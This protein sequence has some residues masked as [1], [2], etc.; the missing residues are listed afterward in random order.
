[1]GIITF[2]GVDSSS[3][4]M[5]VETPPNYEIPEKVYSITQ[6]P[7][8]NGDIIIDTKAYKNVDRKYDIAIGARGAKF[9]SL[10]SKI[11]EWLQSGNGYVRLEDSYDPDVFMLALY[12]DGLEILNILQQAGRASIA[13]HRKPQR[14]LKS[15]EKPIV[16][17][18]GGTLKN[19]TQ[20]Q[21]L[22]RIKIYG[23]NS[24]SVKIGKYEI[25][26]EK[27]IDHVIVDS[28]IGDAF[29]DDSSSNLL[30]ELVNGFPKLESVNEISFSGGITKV[31]IIP[32]WW[33]I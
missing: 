20:Y 28:E 2:N 16:F 10:A 11:A 26:I 3:F 27:I 22:P 18:S 17:T 5:V 9:A 33:R 4:D 15:G 6:V 32:R 29:K 8:R 30:V 14:F 21:S 31:E 23:S 25:K 7:G 12:K 1:M 19:P 24:G 13:F